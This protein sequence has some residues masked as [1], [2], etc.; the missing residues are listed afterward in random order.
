[1]KILKAIKCFRKNFPNLSCDGFE[2]LVHLTQELKN[3]KLVKSVCDHLSVQG[4]LAL[5]ETITAISD[6]DD[7]YI[8]GD[9]KNE[10]FQL[11]F[12]TTMQ[13]VNVAKQAILEGKI[14]ICDDLQLWKHLQY[15]ALDSGRIPYEFVEKLYLYFS[16][17]SQI[18]TLNMLRH[19]FLK[20]FDSTLSE[21]A[22]AY[23][24]KIRKNPEI[25]N[26]YAFLSDFA[27]Q[28]ITSKSLEELPSV[29]THYL[30]LEYA[31]ILDQVDWYRLAVSLKTCTHQICFGLHHALKYR[32]GQIVFCLKYP[33]IRP[34]MSQR[35]TKIDDLEACLDKWKEGADLSI[36]APSNQRLFEHP[37]LK[38]P[39]DN[40]KLI[41]NQ[42]LY[43]KPKAN[44]PLNSR[45]K[46]ISATGFNQLMQDPYG[47]YAR[48]ILKLLPLER[49][50]A[51]FAAKEF[52]INTHKLIE[53]YIKHGHQSALDHIERLQLESPKI[54]WHSRL[55]RVIYWIDKQFHE[56]KPIKANAETSFETGLSNRISIKARI[57]ACIFTELGSL[58]V[59]FKTGT[60]P[61][62][63]DVITGYC[64]QLL[65]EIFLCQTA[66]PLTKIQGEFW[67]LKGSQPPG[68][69]TSNIVL[70]LDKIKENLEKIT[71][72]YLQSFKPFLACPWPLKRTKYNDY[73]YLERI[74]NDR[75]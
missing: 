4:Q 53:I 34:L 42:A 16:N 11:C 67:H 75:I 8:G 52:G 28:L 40:S 36:L 61:S 44:P 19:P 15:S 59:N 66:N 35:L 2:N 26:H 9:T 21:E 29:L 51:Y 43:D 46:V 63:T 57:D 14:L 7:H 73:L 60:P 3:L 20:K 22:L 56:L 70:P 25:W 54:L 68:V 17:P 30:P 12:S 13:L 31:E 45:P 27:N 55:K 39:I 32:P 38:N 1:M 71:N 49:S 69:V 33:Q 37:L 64:P 62:K 5:A 58:V 48:Y 10:T 6:I 41:Q 23:E 47:F 72:H 24:Y 65:V 50:G 74:D 18:T